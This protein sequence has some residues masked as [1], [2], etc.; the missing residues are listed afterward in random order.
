MYLRAE[1]T[2]PRRGEE[3]GNWSRL[4]EPMDW[5]LFCGGGGDRGKV[6]GG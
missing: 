5:A 6:K 1:A 2:L 4:A 3:L